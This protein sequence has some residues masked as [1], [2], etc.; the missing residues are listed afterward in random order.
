MAQLSDDQ[1]MYSKLTGQ[2]TTLSLSTT[3]GSLTSDLGNGIYYITSDIDCFLKQGA[4]ATSALSATTGSGIPLW[5]KTYMRLHVD[6]GGVG[7][8]A[9]IAA[10]TAAGTGTL[11]C[12]PGRT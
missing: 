11:Y 12:I 9:R 10:I 8:N 5:G 1:V 3:T 2:T 7:G 4:S 6:T